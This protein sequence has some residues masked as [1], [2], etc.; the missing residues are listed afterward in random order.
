MAMAD[1]DADVVMPVAA[2]GRK[3]VSVAYFLWFVG[4]WFGLHHFYLRRDR[5]AFVWCCTLGG[6]FGIG[7]L[8]DLV[9]MSEYVAE[10]NG[11]AGFEAELAARASRGRPA[12]SLSRFAGEIIVGW[13]FGTLARCLM[14]EGLTE[15]VRSV[16]LLLPPAIALGKKLATLSIILTFDNQRL[17][18]SYY[19]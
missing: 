9:Q 15:S 7:L 3:R 11:D 18:C 13:L 6:G 10:A 19:K 2:S 16:D 1:D 4:G 8:R 17:I 14:P 5:Q 12:F